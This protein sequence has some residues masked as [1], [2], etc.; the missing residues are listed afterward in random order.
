MTLVSAEPEQ[1]TGYGRVI[2]KSPDSPEVVAIVEQKML[3]PEQLS[4]ARSEHGHVCLQ[5][6]AA[7][8]ASR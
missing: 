2:H 5:D 7:A 3:T 4:A 8:R 1:P 6:R